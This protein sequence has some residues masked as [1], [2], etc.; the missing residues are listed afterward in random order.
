M[1]NS[2]RSRAPRW[3]VWGATALITLGCGLRLANLGQFI[4]WYD[5]ISTLHHVAAQPEQQI[6]QSWLGKVQ[7]FA[8]LH[9]SLAKEPRRRAI[10]TIRSLATTNAHHPPLYYLLLRL[11]ADWF[12]NTITSLRA[13]TALMGLLLLPSLFWMLREAA[14]DRPSL[15]WIGT[16][17]VALSPLQLLYAQE[18]RE[19]ALWLIFT[20]LSSG[21]LLRAVRR[22]PAGLNHRLPD[23]DWGLYAL[24]LTLCWY[25]HLFGG[26][27]LLAHGLFVLRQAFSQPK[28]LIG[29]RLVILRP[30]LLSAGVTIV[31]FSPWLW[32]LRRVADNSI[33]ALQWL[34]T[35]ATGNLNQ[36]AALRSLATTW[37][38][39]Q[40][41]LWQTF[42]QRSDLWVLLALAIG[43][44]AV[45]RLIRSPDRPLKWLVLSL[46][47][48]FFFGLWLPAFLGD[49]ALAY[50][51]RYQ[52]PAMIALQIAVADWLA[53]QLDRPIQADL[54]QQRDRPWHHP[55]PWAIG[56]VLCLL[57]AS[58][59]SLKAR[60]WQI[61]WWHKGGGSAVAIAKILDTVDRPLVISALAPGEYFALL[62]HSTSL[63]R[64]HN[65]TVEFWMVA[66]P[67]QPI[68]PDRPNVLT[69]GPSPILR[70][71]IERQRGPLIPLGPSYLQ[72]W[73][74]RSAVSR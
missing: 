71:A 6:V 22:S 42:P 28:H 1:I 67:E 38:D 3:V 44:A 10:D 70:Q 55:Q 66:D 63:Q 35:P 68:W 50:V 65:R 2:N 39:N 36:W 30:W 18:A 73:R 59:T 33:G 7:V 15:P 61:T 4:P 34:A 17:F 14:P 20:M 27:I 21:L 23:R 69:I 5:E 12:G 31:A 46:I 53:T 60:S 19:Y 26:L 29:D 32:V 40:A 72:I 57:W 16:V 45:V 64:L 56:L 54:G 58:F 62:S 37:I 24:A 52:L 41:S 25:S 9:Q 13:A 49:R 47:A 51:V 74:V 43:G 8:D 11:W 48:P